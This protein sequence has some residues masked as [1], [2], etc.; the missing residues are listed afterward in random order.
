MAARPEGR[1]AGPDLRV[2]NMSV[3]NMH[4]KGNCNL[5][6]AHLFMDPSGRW[7]EGRLAREAREAAAKEICRTCPILI[8]CRE[9]A[10]THREA[11]IWGGMTAL[12]RYNAG[13]PVI[14]AINETQRR[15]RN[16]KKD[17][18]QAPVP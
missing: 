10:M 17:A 4:G 15:E 7:H 8:Q 18:Q 11:H 9:W 2:Y 1:P 5:D 14:K 13:A 16:R 6:N 12:E 3:H